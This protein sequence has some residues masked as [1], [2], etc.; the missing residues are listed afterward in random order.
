VAAGIGESRAAVVLEPDALAQ[1]IRISCLSAAG[2]T[3]RVAVIRQA[4]EQLA[5][6][7]SLA[8]YLDAHW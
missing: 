2:Q 1:Y 5:K 7:P 4:V 3:A 8:L 6:L